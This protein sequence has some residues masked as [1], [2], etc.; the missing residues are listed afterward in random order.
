MT[1]GYDEGAVYQDADVEQAMLAERSF[2]Q[3]LLEAQGRCPHDGVLGRG[4]G[5]GPLAN[6][7]Y[8]PEQEFIPE[9]HYKCHK[10]GEMFP[11]KRDWD[12]AR[13]AARPPLR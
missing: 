5:N 6:G 8:F 1:F 7:H 9:G 11:S 12:I 10:C 4:D 13:R 3:G 2:E